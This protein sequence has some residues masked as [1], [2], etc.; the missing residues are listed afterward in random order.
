MSVRRLPVAESVFRQ[1]ISHGENQQR[2]AEILFWR[3]ADG[4]NLKGYVETL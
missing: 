2:F 1:N 3:N 4:N